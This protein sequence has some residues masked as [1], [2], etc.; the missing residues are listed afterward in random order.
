MDR[1]KHVV[2]RIA[3]IA[4]ICAALAVFGGGVGGARFGI[5][6]AAKAA[7]SQLT[8]MGVGGCSSSAAVGLTIDGTANVA[9]GSGTSQTITLTTSHSN[10]VIILMSESNGSSSGTVISGISDT[11]GLTWAR[12]KT[13]A[14]GEL[15]LEE[16]YATSA[17]PLSSD[18]ITVS[19]NASTTYIE[20]TAFGIN[21]SH[22]AAPFDT[23]VSLPGS[24]ASGNGSITTS[25]A[26]DM[27]IALFRQAGATCGTSG[28]TTVTPG[29]FSCSQTLVVSATQSGLTITDPDSNNG[30]ITDAVIQGP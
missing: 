6:G 12:R 25:N 23:N 14:V 30:W 2:W 26:N 15:A 24:G 1:L 3:P 10:D 29:S 19:Y 9:N 21:G 20:L 4:L 16:W 18:S 8:L 13:N 7:C 5:V 17:S 27:L 11:A 28:F 22:P